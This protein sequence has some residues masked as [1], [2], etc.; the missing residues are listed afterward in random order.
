MPKHRYRCHGCGRGFKPRD[1]TAGTRC[2]YCGVRPSEGEL[3]DQA[4]IGVIVLL[5]LIGFVILAMVMGKT[6]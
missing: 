5:C 6:R 3:Q 1:W 4:V 2:P